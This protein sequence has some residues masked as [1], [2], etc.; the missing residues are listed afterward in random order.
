L[1][2]GTAKGPATR[3]HGT[4]NRC[5]YEK[6]VFICIF[7]GERQIFGSGGR[8]EYQQRCAEQSCMA[9]SFEDVHFV[10]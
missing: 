3:Y 8:R 2:R 1:L 9:E 4:V 7:Q 5:A 6:V 10:S